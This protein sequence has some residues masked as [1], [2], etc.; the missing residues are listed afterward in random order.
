MPYERFDK[1]NRLLHKFQEMKK[2][3]KVEDCPCMMVGSEMGK[4]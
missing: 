2:T 1:F 3:V 4:V